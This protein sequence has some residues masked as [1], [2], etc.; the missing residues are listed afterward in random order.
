MEG[1]IEER[2]ESV[3]VGMGREVDDD[4]DERSAEA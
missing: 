3:L 2:I 4:G 1:S